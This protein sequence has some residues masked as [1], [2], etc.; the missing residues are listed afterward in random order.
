M[1]RNMFKAKLHRAT[2]TD[3]N[4]NYE[5]SVTI[6]KDLL[7]ASGIL[8]FEKVDI[9]NITNGSRFS[10][11]VLEGRRGSGEICLNGAA[12]RLVQVGDR[13]IIATFA[14][15]DE[16]ELEGFKPTVVQLD[17]HNRIVS[18]DGVLV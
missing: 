17:E 10:T 11:Y 4:L 14:M 12:A 16:K 13:V 5:G 9:W 3:A 1:L 2:V 8:E 6:D 18:K 15:M 7:D